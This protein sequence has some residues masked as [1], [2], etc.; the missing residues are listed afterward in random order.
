MRKIALVTGGH[1]QISMDISIQ[2]SLKFDVIHFSSN[3]DQA[4]HD[5]F[6]DALSVSVSQ[7]DLTDKA[8]IDKEIQRIQTEFNKEISVVVFAH[9]SRDKNLSKSIKLELENPIYLIDTIIKYQPAQHLQSVVFFSSPASEKIIA[10]QELTYHLTKSCI[11]QAVRFL[12]FQYA[13]LG[14]RVNGIAP[15]SFVKKLRSENYYL[16]NP[17]YLNRILEFLPERELVSTKSIATL[18][19]F[20]ATPA[21]KGVNGQ[22]I[23]IDGGY[24]NLEESNYFI[25]ANKP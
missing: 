2:L 22:I 17:E 6:R 11:N 3:P 4:L 9:R 14:I 24:S 25:Q 5:Y 1:S 10:D 8:A 7:L 13:D 15:G 20:L 12:P 21:S 16:E 18:V 19:E 23:K